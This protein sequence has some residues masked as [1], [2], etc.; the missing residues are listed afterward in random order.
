M[1]R[2]TRAKIKTRKTFEVE[3]LK[4]RINGILASD[5]GRDQHFR[6]AL[7]TVLEG[8]LLDTG[9]YKGFRYLLKGEAG[10]L[11]G[12][13][14]LDGQPHPDYIER[15]KNTDSTRVEYF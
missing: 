8:V 14:Y 10:G 4:N 7:L 9:N 3:V 13:N 5:S 12:I 11:P 2:K 15:F 6:V 1:D